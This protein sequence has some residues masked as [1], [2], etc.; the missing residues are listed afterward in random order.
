MAL[1]IATPLPCA[2]LCALTLCNLC[3]FPAVSLYGL[4]R[5][6]FVQLVRWGLAKTLVAQGRRPAASGHIPLMVRHQI[7]HREASERVLALMRM[8]LERAQ[9]GTE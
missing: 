7:P 3:A 4:V 2:A 9:M 6:K 5:N 8:L 1:P